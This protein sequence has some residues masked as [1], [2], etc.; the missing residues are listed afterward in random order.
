[1]KNHLSIELSI[2]SGARFSLG[3]RGGRSLGVTRL[4]EW[5]TVRL[6]LS[7]V[8]ASTIGVENWGYI[9]RDT[10]RLGLAG[11]EFLPG[12]GAFMDDI[13]G[14]AIGCVSRMV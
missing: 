12:L 11:D 8:L 5:A 10:T 4:G 1:M 9:R 6:V 13:H 2:G 3:G 14:I 7:G